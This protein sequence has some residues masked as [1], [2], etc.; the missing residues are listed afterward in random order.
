MKNHIQKLSFAILFFLAVGLQAQEKLQTRGQLPD[1]VFETSGL[2]F[3]NE[4]LITH[5]DSGNEPILYELDTLNLSI[6]R[7][8]TISN[9]DNIDWE[10]ITQDEE[11]IYI[12]DFGNN[13]GT[14]VDLAI[15]RISKED[16]ISFDAVEAT[17]INFSYEDQEDFTNNGNSD[18]D[19]EAFFILN[20]Q[21]VILT[22]Q[23]KSF[24]SV[25]YTLP[26]T[27]GIHEAN[28]VGAIADVG[29]V[30][31]VT[32]DVATNRL[33]LM[34]YSTILSPFIGIVEDLNLESPFD[35][36]IQ[37]NLGLNFVQA[38]GITQINST[39]YFFTSEYYSRQSPTIESI[40]RLFSFQILADE[41]EIPEEPEVPVTPETPE[42][43]ENPE[44]ENAEGNDMLVIFKDNSTN[45]YHYSLSTNKEIYGQIIYDVSGRLVWQNLGNIEKKGTISQHLESSIYYL[46][47]YLE[48]GIIA[49]PFAVYQ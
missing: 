41:P 1:E 45:Q 26:I 33:V 10:A 21:F 15:H 22:K 23:W 9:V 16:F 49:K 13:L 8:I 14:R 29:L 5:N 42:E 38:E 28:R 43:T 30:T 47:L 31:D 25:A 34:G 39:N 18:W 48:D 27:P 44:P 32:Y 4:S 11:Y 20:N 24:G 37:Q 35:G 17:S 6:K 46:T 40:S 12:G 36:Y 19:A 2:I 3:F 7:R